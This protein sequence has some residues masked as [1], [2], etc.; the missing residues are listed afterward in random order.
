MLMNDTDLD[1]D[2]HNAT[3]LVVDDEPFNLTLINKMLSADGYKNIIT[4][5]DPREVKDVYAAQRIDLVLLDINMPYMDGFEL[6]DLLKQ[7]H[8]AQLAPILVLTAQS[9]QE[10][11]IKALDSGARDYVTKPFDRHELIARVRNLIELQLTNRYLQEQKYLLEKKVDERTRELRDSQDQVVRRLG[12]AAEYRENESSAH[13][14]RVSEL[15][16]LL[17]RA[18]GLPDDVVDLMYRACPL[19]DLGKIGIPDDILLKPGPLDEQEWSVMKNHVQIGA[20]ILVGE[21][22][23]FIS[24]ARE[25]ALNHHEKWDGSGYPQGLKGEEIPMTARIMALV[26][27]F[28][29]MLC[30][31]PYREKLPMQKALDY[32]QEESGRHFQPELVELFVKNLDKVA[33]IQEKYP[34]PDE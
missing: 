6:I 28:D 5:E 21:S 7:E 33:E 9:L 14:I 16:A 19:H 27:A 17:G 10:F 25:I 13:I 26:D 15:A 11:R 4:I 29:S 22:S 2:I 8:G 34:D 31:R 12:E 32:I 23:R 24:V 1:L 30:K 20:G 18:A 3:I